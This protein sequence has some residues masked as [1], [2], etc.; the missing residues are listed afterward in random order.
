MNSLHFFTKEEIVF[1]LAKRS[2]PA[3]ELYLQKLV[4]FLHSN[5]PGRF[6]RS[7]SYFTLTA[8]G[9]QN[10]SAGSEIQWAHHI[11]VQVWLALRVQ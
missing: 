8:S 4:A 2:R 5:D 9:L 3:H 7:A 10:E 11:S 6:K 1:D